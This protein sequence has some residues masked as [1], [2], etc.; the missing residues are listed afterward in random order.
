[1]QA[2]ATPLSVR[3]GPFGQDQQYGPVVVRW[4]WG[5]P[6][7]SVARVRGIGARCP[8]SVH[9]PGGRRVGWSS[10]APGA[11]RGLSAGAA[12]VRARSGLERPDLAVGELDLAPSPIAESDR[13]APRRR[14]RRRAARFARRA[15]SRPRSHPPARGGRRSG[16]ARPVASRRPRSRPTA[17]RGRS[18]PPP[19]TRRRTGPSSLE[20]QVADPVG[21]HDVPVED[22]LVA[23]GVEGQQAGRRRHL[24]PHGRPSGSVSKQ[25]RPDD[26]PSRV[27]A[28]RQ[29][30]PRRPSAIDQTIASPSGS[31][32]PTA[33]AQHP[34]ESGGRLMRRLAA[35]G[36]PVAVVPVRARRRGGRLELAGERGR[37]PPRTRTSSP[38]YS[39]LDRAALAHPREEV[40]GGVR[41]VDVDVDPERGEDGRQLGPQRVEAVAGHAR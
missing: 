35:A 7:T 6:R 19:A 9:G 38:R 39:T 28:S 24:E 26:L 29:R 2:P 1:M 32:S 4:L 41:D 17:G 11:G 15:G 14:G 25:D 22:R 34:P 10:R 8:R 36:A 5:Y 37:D 21:R 3:H 40:A 31:S 20:R 33:Q 13:R 18:P 12:Q 27:A 30:R 16:A 23:L